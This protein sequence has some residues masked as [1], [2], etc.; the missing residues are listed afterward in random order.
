M[1]VDEV[2]RREDGRSGWHL[3]LARNLNDWEADEFTR[4]LQLLADVHLDS[5]KDKVV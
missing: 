1:V 2:F 3:S 4:L 5:N